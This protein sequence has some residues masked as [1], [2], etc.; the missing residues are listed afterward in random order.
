MKL[1]T[2]QSSI[3]WP[4]SHFRVQRQLIWF[5]CSCAV[6]LAALISVALYRLYLTF[7]H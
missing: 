4:L 2:W 6:V 1:R 5:W 3:H 7:A